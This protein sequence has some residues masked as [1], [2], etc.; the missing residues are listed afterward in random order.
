MLLSGVIDDRIA[1]EPPQLAQRLAQQEL[2]ASFGLFALRETG[3][4]AI[5]DE[6]CGVAAKGLA[7][8][9]AKVLEF[10]PQSDDLLMRNGVGWKPGVV[11]HVTIGADT[12][13]PAGFALKIRMP[14]V[15]N[16]LAAES[17]FRTPAVLADHNVHRAINVMIG[18]DHGAPFGVLEADSTERQHYTSHDIAFLQ[19]VANVLAASVERERHT[20]A[21]EA[22]LREKDLL[23]QE[24][25]HR[26]KNSLQLVQT[27]LHLQARSIQDH[28]ERSRLDDAGARI[29]S[30]AAVHERLYD[31]GATDQVQLGPYLSS[32]LT[33]ICTPLGDM[34]PPSVEADDVSL[35]P[36]QITPIG[37][38]TAELVTNALKYGA[39]PIG[40]RVK[41]AADEAEITVTDG[42]A[43]FPEGF[44]PTKTASLGMRLIAAMARRKDGITV[45]KLNTGTR[46]RVLCAI[47]E[48]S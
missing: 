45:E 7:A 47:T 31:G 13:S 11:G 8:Q 30:I 46:I 25:H 22:L 20:Q 16:H 6:G 2:V 14:V 19:A 36:E 15:S 26:V 28:G 43:G 42:G 34:P 4:D 44:D 41:I 32:L 21:R 48:R 35:R 39:A 18:S 27:L 9:F 29:R 5:L 33:G 1:T 17:R 12:A 37:L 38:I 10:R 24:V 23:M 40:I 3:L